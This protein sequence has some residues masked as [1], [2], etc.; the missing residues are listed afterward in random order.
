MTSARYRASRSLERPSGHASIQPCSRPWR[1][2]WTLCLSLGGSFLQA[3]PWRPSAIESTDGK[4]P[5]VASFRS[6]LSIQAPWLYTSVCCHIWRADR[7]PQCQQTVSPAL[8]PCLAFSLALISAGKAYNW[9]A[10]GSLT[11]PSPV[12]LAIWSRAYALVCS[13]KLASRSKAGLPG[14][15]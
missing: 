12:G 6:C 15:Q 13:V 2:C 11:G 1:R 14:S 5:T 7:A 10:K 8:Y 9:H 4:L 3:S